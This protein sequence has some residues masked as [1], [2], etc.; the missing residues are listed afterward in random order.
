MD[1]EKKGV[2][3]PCREQITCLWSRADD[4]TSL[5]ETTCKQTWA[6]YEGTPKENNMN[7]CPFCGKKLIDDSDLIDPIEQTEAALAAE[8]ISL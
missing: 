5:W 2:P 8:I 1:T 3:P 7:Y 4:D 6:L